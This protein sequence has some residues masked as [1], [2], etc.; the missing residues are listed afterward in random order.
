M[1]EVKTVSDVL[2]VLI[3][4]F[5]IVSSSIDKE[6]N[7]VEKPIEESKKTLLEA[8]EHVSDVSAK[9]MSHLQPNE[10]YNTQKCKSLFYL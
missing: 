6:W 5:E 4:S 9:C 8:I 1:Q 3:A 10:P 7:V 2:T